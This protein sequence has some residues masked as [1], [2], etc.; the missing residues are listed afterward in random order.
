[1]MIEKICP[2]CGLGTLVERGIDHVIKESYGGSVTLPI[3]E[4]YCDTCESHGDF[5]DENED[6]IETKTEM[7]KKKAIENILN[8][9]LDNGMSMAAMERA[10]SLPQRTLTKWKNGVSL[11]TAPGIALMK[12]LRTFPWLLEVADH[13]FEYDKAQK[14]FL[15]NALND[16][17][18]ALNFRKSSTFTVDDNESSFVSLTFVKIHTQGQENPDKTIYIDMNE[19]GEKGS[20]SS[21][22]VTG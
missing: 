10:L 1:M 6:I 22:S 19:A 8:D 20:F 5:F 4:Y 17:V 13:D 3:K 14:I 11:P 15:N 12:F 7:L 18:T 9:F 2:V 16:F 21:N